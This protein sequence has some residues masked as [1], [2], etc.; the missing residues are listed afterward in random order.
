[1]QIKPLRPDLKKVLKKHRLVKK[2]AKQKS[3]FEKNHKYPS[4]NTEKLK[5]KRLNIYSF[6]LDKKWW[7]IFIIAE[8]KAEVIDIN[9][10]YQ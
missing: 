6:R 2:F 5:P 1:M 9:L 8:E 7:A 3:F 4:L 10:H